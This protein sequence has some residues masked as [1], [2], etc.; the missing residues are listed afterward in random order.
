MIKNSF[1]FFL[2]Q[3]KYCKKQSKNFERTTASLLQHEQKKI[4]EHAK[5]CG[6][7]KKT[8]TT[9]RENQTLFST[10][11]GI[12]LDFSFFALKRGG[13]LPEYSLCFVQYFRWPEKLIFNSFFFIF[14]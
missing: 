11:F 1:C 2:C 8:E 13:F 7:T 5:K 10:F 14:Y 4:K 3:R 12:F 6:K 9:Q